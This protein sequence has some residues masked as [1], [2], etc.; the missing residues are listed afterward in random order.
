M[1][2]PGTGKSL[3][4]KVIAGVW[5]QP[6]L[7][8]DMGAIFGSLVGQS[9]ENI[10]KA[11]KLAETVSPCILWIDEVEKGLSDSAG[12]SGTSARVFGTL[13]SWM[14]EKEKPVFVVATANIVGNNQNEAKNNNGCTDHKQDKTQNT[15]QQP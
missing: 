9:E 15:L 13:L 2:I 8:L 12:D 10:R 7:R 5:R 11:L 6:L 14:E 3:T 4:A 1:G